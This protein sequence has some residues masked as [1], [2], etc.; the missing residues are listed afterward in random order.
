MP[1]Y[2]IISVGKENSYGHPSEEIISRLKDAGAI[3]FR[4]DE[5]G[6]I[7]CISNGYVVSFDFAKQ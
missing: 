2:A 3:I 5:L 1:S 6:M 7:H 4:T